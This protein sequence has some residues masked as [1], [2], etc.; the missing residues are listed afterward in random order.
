METM[1]DNIKRYN[2]YNKKRLVKSGIVFNYKL[3]CTF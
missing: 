3:D 1:G 2:K